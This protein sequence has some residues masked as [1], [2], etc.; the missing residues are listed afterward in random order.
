MSESS[1]SENK[2]VKFL[3]SR[4]PVEVSCLVQWDSTNRALFSLPLL[5]LF[6]FILLSFYMSNTH[7]YACSCTHKQLHQHAKTQIS[8]L[9][10]QIFIFHCLLSLFHRA[11]FEGSKIGLVNIL[12]KP[13]FKD[14]LWSLFTIKFSLK[15]SF[16]FLYSVPTVCAYT[17]VHCVSLCNNVWCAT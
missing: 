4:R 11:V 2:L 5:S 13:P 14:T 16:W 3:Q 9:Q 17:F 10:V 8:P 1:L 7:K 15:L 6:F 12:P